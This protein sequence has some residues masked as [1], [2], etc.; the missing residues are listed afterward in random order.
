MVG[1]R[2]L[3][4]M[5]TIFIFWLSRLYILEYFLEF[6]FPIFEKETRLR[7]LRK[8]FILL[9]HL[10]K[11][12]NLRF[13]QRRLYF[14]HFGLSLKKLIHEFWILNFRLLTKKYLLNRR[15][16]FPRILTPYLPI[17]ILPLRPENSFKYL[18]QPYNIN[19]YLRLPCLW[20]SRS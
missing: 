20:L 6:L 12:D 5:S 10:R 14:R 1:E 13:Y 11:F 17:V 4:Y 8:V 3:H 9:S 7:R 15:L 19:V 16:Q 2:F 18:S